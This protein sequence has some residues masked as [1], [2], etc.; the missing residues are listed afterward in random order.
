MTLCPASPAQRNPAPKARAGAGNQNGPVGHGGPSRLSVPLGSLTAKTAQSIDGAGQAKIGS[1]EVRKPL[2]VA[3]L[4]VK[5][6]SGGGTDQRRRSGRQE[7][8][9]GSRQ[10]RSNPAPSRNPAPRRRAA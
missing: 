3:E 2:A 5:G 8:P 4:A 7:R 9:A 10:R 6:Q 1:G